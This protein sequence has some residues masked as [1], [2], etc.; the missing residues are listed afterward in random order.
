MT[1]IKLLLVLTAATAVVAMATTA[2]AAA[3]GIADHFGFGPVRSGTPVAAAHFELSS[4]D[5]RNNQAI[6]LAQVANIFGCHGGNQA[7]RLQ[8]SGAPAGTQSYAVTMF[9]PYAPTGSG[10]WH[11]LVWDIPASDHS[12]SGTPPAGAVS[13]TN[14][15]GLTGYLGPCPPPGDI[16]HRYQLTVFAL[17]VP[18]L[19]LPPET[20]AAVVGFVMRTHILATGQLIGTYQQ[21]G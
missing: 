9:D 15:A 6:A 5:L 14:D 11:W 1:R 20:H 16:V 2:G 7:P 4:P 8:W 21:P 19:G 17:D 12:L 13:G 3:T 10:F 18:S